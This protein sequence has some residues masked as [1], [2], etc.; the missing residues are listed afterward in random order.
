[1]H[2]AS[3]LKSGTERDAVP[4]LPSSRGDEERGDHAAQIA[5]PPSLFT[6]AKTLPGKSAQ[7]KKAMSLLWSLVEPLRLTLA[8][9]FLVMIANR[10]S[11]YALPIASRYL[12]N[13]VLYLRRFDRLPPI[14]G[15]VALATIFQGVTTFFLNQWLALSGQRMIAD[16]RMR[17]QKHVLHLPI[18]FFDST[19]AGELATR[20]MND[21]EGVGNLVGAGFIDLCGG[22][23]ASLI[24]LGILLRISATMTALT[25]LILIGFSLFLKNAFGLTRPIFRERSQIAA[26]T[27]ARLV[28]SLGGIRVV[29]GY[30]AEQYEEA[31]FATGVRR[32]LQSFSRSI[33]V[34]SYMSLGS[35]IAIG[36]VGVLIMALGA[37][38]VQMGRLDVGD[39]VEFNMLLAFMIAPVA[40]LVS[41]GTRVTEALAGLERTA[42][43][44]NH[45]P[46]EDGGR[47]TS[48]IGPIRGEI[49]FE[50]VS[51][52]YIPGVPVLHNINLRTEAGSVTAL[53]GSSGSGKS[54]IIS[55]VCGFHHATAGRVLVDQRDIR[56]IQRGSYRSQ[57]G[58]VLQ[59]PF[60]FEGSIR[61]NVLFSRPHATGRQWMDACRIARVDEFAER[62]PDG[63]DTLIGER[64]VKLSGGQRQR[65]SI[66]RAILAD[67]RILIL[68][69][70]T[71]SLDSESEAL[72]QSGLSFLMQ[73]RTTF[74]IAHRLSTI[75]RAHQILVVE[76]GRIIERGTH[77]SLY[78]L[79]GRYRNLYDR[80]YERDSNLFLAAGEGGE[81]SSSLSFS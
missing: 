79:H 44:L 2:R 56:D 62:L 63:Y 73:D 55:L 81:A 47:S 16:L 32:L 15:A 76:E 77:E 19:R 54:T 12:I 72:I 17:V 70:A 20:L 14:L 27:T 48:A 18:S 58:M 4:V 60:L 50:E 80:Q 11:S 34:Q 29:K 57:L 49:M 65:L 9:S 36:L 74:V 46:E 10:I 68:D 1:M 38:E 24:G 33:T 41:V 61:E 37:H 66:A 43:L 26:E 35:I 6:G 40:L 64:G 25:A 69:E 13:D 71:S 75:R 52:S 51:F 53:V 23:L 8:G 28:E 42:E 67:P 39:Y 22:I 45:A 21:V 5:G 59:E 3:T 31:V 7:I 30:H 78:R